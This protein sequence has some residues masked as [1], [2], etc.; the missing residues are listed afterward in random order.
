MKKHLH[1]KNSPAAIGPYSQAVLVDNLVFLS[2]QIPLNNKGKIVA[3][4]VEQQAQQIFTNIEAILVEAGGTL[5]DLVKLTI[6][7]TS[8]DDFEVINKT[9]M[10]RLTRPYPARSCVEVSALPKSST[11]EVEAIAR[12]S[13]HTKLHA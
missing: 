9:M 2:G 12:I 10:S 13:L 4:T 7:L 11:V 5:N 6:F 3:G 8:L 1:T